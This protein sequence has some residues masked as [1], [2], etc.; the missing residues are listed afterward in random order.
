MGSSKRLVSADSD[1]KHVWG[2]EVLQEGVTVRANS[3]KDRNPGTWD[4]AY[5]GLW[6]WACSSGPWDD[7]PSTP[8]HLSPPYLFTSPWHSGC[9]RALTPPFP[10]T[11]KS[12]FFPPPVWLQPPPPQENIHSS[13]AWKSSPP[14]HQGF[15]GTVVPIV[16]LYKLLGWAPIVS[17]TLTPWDFLVIQWLRLWAP[18]AGNWSL[19]RELLIDPM[20]HSWGSGIPQGR[21]KT[22]VPQPRL[23]TAK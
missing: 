15:P 8:V 20:C 16:S 19:V 9:A 21:L 11:P 23:S 5:G 1:P 22:L 18:S 13:L 12:S 7:G 6:G 4:V 2:E 10:Q 14:P 3:S 17:S